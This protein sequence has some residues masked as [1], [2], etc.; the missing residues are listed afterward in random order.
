MHDLVKFIL[1]PPTPQSAQFADPLPQAEL[2]FSRSAA[3]VRFGAYSK[4]KPSVFFFRYIDTNC[5]V[6]V[7]DQ[8]WTN[9]Q[10]RVQR[11][12]F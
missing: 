3:K 2:S 7:I 11:S 8:P 12:R 1:T 5:L 6:T 4:F 10:R 9:V